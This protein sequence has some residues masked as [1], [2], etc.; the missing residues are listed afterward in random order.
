VKLSRNSKSVIL[1]LTLAPAL[2]IIVASVVTV[3]K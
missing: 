1:L 3:S 2:R